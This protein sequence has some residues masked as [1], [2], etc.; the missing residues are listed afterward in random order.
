MVLYFLG[1]LFLF[2]QLFKP[3]FSVGVAMG[4]AGPTAG[5]FL[6]VQKVG[7]QASYMLLFC[8]LLFYRCDPTDPF[9]FGKRSEGVP[10]LL[11]FWC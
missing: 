3:F 4:A 1:L 8:F 9:V 6:S 7:L 2:L 11:Y 5:S 10:C